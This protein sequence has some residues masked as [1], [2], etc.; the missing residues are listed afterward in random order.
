M[1][2]DGHEYGRQRAERGPR[3]GGVFR[4]GPGEGRGR[5]QIQSQ[6]PAIHSQP[7]GQVGKLREVGQE[8]GSTRAFRLKDRNVRESRSARKQVPRPEIPVD[9]A[10]MRGR[11][12]QPPPGP[13]HA[14][15]GGQCAEKPGPRW[16]RGQP[17]QVTL[18]I[19]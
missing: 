9:E 3:Q 14:F 4:V 1:L 19:Q 7:E 2:P 16:R 12:V 18:G 6:A 10:V 15:D 5:H 11:V 8:R 17:L 13:R